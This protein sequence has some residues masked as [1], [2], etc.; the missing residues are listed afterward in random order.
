MIVANILAALVH[1]TVIEI[2]G[3]WVVKCAQAGRCTVMM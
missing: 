2:W 1:F 3:E